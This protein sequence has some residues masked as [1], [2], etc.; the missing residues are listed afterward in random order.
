MKAE[1]IYDWIDWIVSDNL[2]FEFTESEKTRAFTKLRSISVT[3][4]KKYMKLLWKKLRGKVEEI[5]KGKKRFGLKTDGWTVD[6]DHFLAIFASFVDETKWKQPEVCDILLS[7]S[8]QADIDVENDDEFHP[9]IE[10]EDRQTDILR[11]E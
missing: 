3:T 6:D 11:T 9:L 10:D 7:C 4:L 1:S 2:S 5:L 8:V